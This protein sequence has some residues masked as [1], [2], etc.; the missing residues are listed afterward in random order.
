MQ[1]TCSLSECNDTG[2]APAPVKR[3]PLY[4]L[5]VELGAKIV[6][7]AGYEMPVHYAPGILKEHLHTRAHAGLFDISHMGQIRLE[8][9]MDIRTQAEKIFSTDIKNLESGSIRYSFLLNEHGGVL[10]DLMVTNPVDQSSGPNL[11][12]IVNASCKDQD[13]IYIQKHVPSLKATMLTDRALLALQGPKAANTLARFC[14]AP[15]KLKFMEAGNFNIQ[16]IGIC[17]I[18]RSGYTGEDGF[19]ISVPNATVE[20]F[21]RKLLTHPEVMAIGLGARD[22]L[23]LE[24]GLCLYGHELD[25][26]ITPIEAGLTWAIAKNRRLEGGFVGA[27]TIQQQLKVG[28]TRKRVALRPEGR[29]LAR[30]HTEIQSTD[31]KKIGEVTS[32]GFGASADGPIAIGYVEAAFA[33]KGTIINLIVRG[34]PLPATVVALPFV[35]HNYVKG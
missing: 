8:G 3:T 24:A 21:A 30:E 2:S 33:S 26:T 11:F 5:H 27:A 14:D 15:T 22:S 12:V 20:A 9:G 16:D 25:P 6:P 1:T 23:R 31:G 35:P 7:F 10:D 17:Y 29:A 34:K 19:E 32:G 13:L 28:V 4:D 18:S